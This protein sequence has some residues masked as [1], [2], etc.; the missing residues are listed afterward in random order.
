M[1]CDMGK[2]EIRWFTGGK[3]NVSGE[4]ANCMAYSHIKMDNDYQL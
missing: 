3:L 4:K 2:G 1:D